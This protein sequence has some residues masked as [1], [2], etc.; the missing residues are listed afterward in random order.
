[1]SKCKELLENHTVKSKKQQDD[2]VFEILAAI[3][4]LNETV[5]DD[6]D[7]IKAKLEEMEKRNRDCHS[8][9]EQIKSI[10]VEYKMEKDSAAHHA[11]VR[12]DPVDLALQN[13]NWF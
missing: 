5:K 2:Q 3:A 1:L 7:F 13:R 11:E 4:N 12:V 9:I 6:K 10:L 8:V